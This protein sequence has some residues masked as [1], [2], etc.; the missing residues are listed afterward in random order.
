MKWEG[1]KQGGREKGRGRGA[2]AYTSYRSAT[3]S[4]SSKNA[5]AAAVV[6]L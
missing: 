5:A 4:S 3:P 2:A 1:E 6:R